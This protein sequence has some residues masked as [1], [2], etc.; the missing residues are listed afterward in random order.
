MKCLLDVL[1]SLQIS[2]SQ[3]YLSTGLTGLQGSKL[4]SALIE[5]F[6]EHRVQ[7][8]MNCLLEA[9]LSLQHPLL[10]QLL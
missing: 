9:P 7:S 10:P 8:M 1:L 3:P 2:I 6:F 5:S 4:L